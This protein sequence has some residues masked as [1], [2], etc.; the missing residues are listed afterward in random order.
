MEE[1]KKKGFGRRLKIS[2]LVALIGG[3][4]F[5]V[6]SKIKW[7]GDANNDWLQSLFFAVLMFFIYL[8]ISKPRKTE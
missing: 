5:F 8:A 2:G 7:F 3:V 4:V 6:L 1:E